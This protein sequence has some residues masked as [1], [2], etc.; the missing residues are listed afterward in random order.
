MR[1]SREAVDPAHNSGKE[2]KMRRMRSAFVLLLVFGVALVG[3]VSHVVAGQRGGGGAPQAVGKFK[4]VTTSISPDRGITWGD[5]QLSFN[6]QD[7]KFRVEATTQTES[8][9]LNYYAGQQMVVEGLVYNLKNVGD[10]AG[11]Y[12]KISPDAIRA[13]GGTGRDPA[14]HNEKDVVLRVTRRAATEMGLY[15]RLLGGTFKIT[16]SGF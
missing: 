8:D 14:F 10:F 7:Y 5:G 4:V 13:M 12:T 15:V 2:A 6:N 9:V 11:T 1:E 3:G 16:L